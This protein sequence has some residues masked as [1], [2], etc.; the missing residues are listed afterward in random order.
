[1]VKKKRKKTFTDNSNGM[2]MQVHVLGNK[3][4]P[5]SHA[6]ENPL[7]ESFWDWAPDWFALNWNSM[8]FRVDFEWGACNFCNV[9][10]LWRDQTYPFRSRKIDGS[11]RSPSDAKNSRVQKNRWNKPWKLI[12]EKQVNWLDS[13][14]NSKVFERHCKKLCE[15]KMWRYI[16]G[17]Y[18]VIDE[19]IQSVSRCLLTVL[20]ITHTIL[21]IVEFH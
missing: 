16:V 12:E 7:Y 5:H 10:H 1:M 2:K 13:N 14:G 9:W 8:E 18:L 19:E 4:S 6:R 3:N 11:S 20:T 17:K 21:L 15:Y